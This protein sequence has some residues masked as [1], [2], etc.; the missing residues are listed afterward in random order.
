VARGDFGTVETHLRWLATQLADPQLN[1]LPD[2][3][4]ALARLALPLALQ[5]GSLTP[6]MAAALKAIL[7]A[8]EPRG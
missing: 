4:T 5:K 2:A 3:Y 1:A 7:R 6:E 8:D